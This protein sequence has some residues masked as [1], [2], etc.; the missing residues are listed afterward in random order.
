MEI[1]TGHLSGY[2]LLCLSRPETLNLLKQFQVVTFMKTLIFLAL[3]WTSFWSG[4]AY[5]ARTPDWSVVVYA[6]TDEEDLAHHTEPLLEKLINQQ[7]IPAE[8]E[9]LMQQ[10][11]YGLEPGRRIV[12]RGNVVSRSSV[13]ETD[14]ADSAALNSFLSWAKSV[15]RGRHTLFLIIGHSWGWKGI[16]QDFSIPGAPDTDSMM[17]VRVFAKT[18]QDSQLSPEVIFFDSCVTGN[19]EFIDEFSGTIPY[20]V[21]SQRETPYAGLP[22]RPL[23]KF[24]SS[25]PSPLDLAKAIPGMYVSAFARDGEMSA[26]EGEYG[27]VTTVSIDM[28]KWENFVLSFKELVG[29]L[30]DHN[31]RETLRAEPMKFAAFTDMDFNI[32]LIEFLKRISSQE[33][34]KKL[35]YNSAESPDSV[36]T[37]DRGDFQLLIQADEILWQNLSSEKFLE[38]ARSRFLEMNKDLITS[39]E[40]FTFKIKI[41]HRKPYLEISPRGPETLQLRPWLPGSRKVIVVQNN[42][43]RSLVRDRDYISL[44]DFPQSSFLIA[45][46]TTQ[47]APFIHGIGLNLN[48]LMDENEER[49]LDP[50]TGLRGPYFYEMTSWNRRVGWGDL[51]HLN[52]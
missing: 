12:K 47:G 4:E 1:I 40:N 28:R 2:L 11:S 35:I 31:F 46:A 22:F 19:A 33:L 45:S 13:P 15:K 38:D 18:L 52:R 42:V 37:L 34:L 7:F 43:K 41:R 27:V 32:D 30:R 48:P 5:T 25:R 16:I 20:F 9:L 3:A 10:D 24:L 51:I 14:S 39:P 6:G 44:K 36:L 29:S 17:P 50:L 49:G 23:L 21:A 8:V 26:E